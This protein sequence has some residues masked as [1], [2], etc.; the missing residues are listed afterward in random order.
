MGLCT[1]S[2]EKIAEDLKNGKIKSAEELKK[3]IAKLPKGQREEAV[4]R[5]QEE[6]RGW[7]PKNEGPVRRGGGGGDGAY[8]WMFGLQD[9]GNPLAKDAPSYADLAYVVGSPEWTARIE[10]TGIGSEGHEIMAF[11]GV[12][13]APAVCGCLWSN[14]AVPAPGWV[15]TK[16][17]VAWTTATGAVATWTQTPG[18]QTLWTNTVGP[19]VN[20]LRETGAGIRDLAYAAGPAITNL[21]QQAHI[22]AESNFPATMEAANAFMRTVTSPEPYVPHTPVESVG[23]AAGMAV[24]NQAVQ[25]ELER[26]VPQPAKD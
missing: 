26:L 13:A 8:D 24:Q 18:A 21:A 16:A 10:G 7:Q 12:Y 17:G 6:L 20:S 9:Y 19:M 22:F 14:A 2:P 3:R 15:G 11:V 1:D 4:R 23:A 5:A 25:S